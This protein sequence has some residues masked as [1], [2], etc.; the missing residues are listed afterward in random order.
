MWIV[1]L[2]VTP[3]TQEISI[4]A[5]PRLDNHFVKASISDAKSTA[6]SSWYGTT[7]YEP[8]LVT[9]PGVYGSIGGR[10]V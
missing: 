1:S 9:K 6:Y 7:P 3:Y 2:I 5:V 8:T 4:K 10:K